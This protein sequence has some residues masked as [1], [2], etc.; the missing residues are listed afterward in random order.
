M[1]PLTLQDGKVSMPQ[2]EFEALVS[3]AVIKLKVFGGEP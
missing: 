1:S 2:D 3:G